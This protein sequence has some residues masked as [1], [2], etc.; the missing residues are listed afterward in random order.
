[1]KWNEEEDKKKP[2]SLCKSIRLYLSYSLSASSATALSLYAHTHTQNFTRKVCPSVPRRKSGFFVLK[3]FF[4][5]SREKNAKRCFCF[6]FEGG[7]PHLPGEKRSPL[8]PF[9]SALVLEKKIFSEMRWTHTKEV[10][11]FPHFL[12]HHITMAASSLTAAAL[13]SKVALHKVRLMNARCCLASSAFFR[14]LLLFCMCARAANGRVYE[15]DNFLCKILS[16]PPVHER[17]TLLPK[18]GKG[19]T[20]RILLRRRGYVSRCERRSFWTRM[21]DLLLISRLVL[22]S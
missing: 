4:T 8:S 9:S 19:A 22:G 3:M 18:R 13:G 6:S 12:Q 5:Y 10:L 11:P 1:M 16:S 14:L 21:K 2:L 17:N 15:R 20:K 7:G